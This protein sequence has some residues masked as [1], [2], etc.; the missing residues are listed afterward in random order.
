VQRTISLK[1]RGQGFHLVDD[2]VLARLPEI[3]AMSAG[4][5]HLH[6]LHTSAS[7]ALS[8]NASPDVRTDLES[9]F[10]EAVREEAPYWRHTL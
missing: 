6:I 9:W 2:E 7:L 5:L 8:E 10:D 3:G 4:L 1:A